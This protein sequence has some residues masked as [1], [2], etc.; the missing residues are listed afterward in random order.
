MTQT[1]VKTP[2]AAIPDAGEKDPRGLRP[3]LWTLPVR[4]LWPVVMWIAIAAMLQFL[5]APHVGGFVTTQ[6]MFAGIN[7]ILAV[8]LTVVNG[9][10]GQFSI[11]HAGFMALGGYAAAAIVYYGSFRAF[12]A[13]D[14]HGGVLS[15]TEA[16]AFSGPPLASGDLLFIGGCLAG[17]IV[18][19]AIG[20]VV[21]LPSLR[22]RGD[23]LAIV[24]LGFGEIVRVIL[25]ATPAELFRSDRAQIAST[26]FPKLLT[27]LGG[28]LGFIY[29]PTYATVFWVWTAVAITLVATVRLKHTS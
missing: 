16:S 29:V 5:L 2:R 23:Y 25:Q 4:A 28:S 6:M 20:W 26:P 1:P 7:I 10:T 22:L 24:T 13:P 14:F 12:G 3:P 17:G 21:G 18:A 27:Y 19:A 11:G 9:F 8:S 15:W